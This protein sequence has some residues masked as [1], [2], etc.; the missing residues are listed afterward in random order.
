MHIIQ[1]GGG[2]PHGTH[3]TLR[4]L[5]RVARLPAGAHRARVALEPLRAS[6]PR[7]ARGAGRAGRPAD[8]GEVLAGATGL[9]QRERS[10]ARHATA[11]SIGG[12]KCKV[13]KPVRYTS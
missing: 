1:G 11:S 6:L 13:R 2:S 10:S 5:D 9:P 8:R 4:P 12:A 7:H 3:G